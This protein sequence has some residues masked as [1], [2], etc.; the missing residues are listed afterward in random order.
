MSANDIKLRPLVVSQLNF[1]ANALTKTNATITVETKISV[2]SATKNNNGTNQA[3][4]MC[5]LRAQSNHQQKSK[6]IFFLLMKASSLFECS[7]V[8]TEKDFKDIIEKQGI[9][10][11]MEEIRKAVANITEDCGYNALNI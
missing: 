3:I 5:E 1:N 6:E 4:I 10:R 7:G 11:F 9:P 2:K 8:I